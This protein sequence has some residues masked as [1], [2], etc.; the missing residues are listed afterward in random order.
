MFSCIYIDSESS[1]PRNWRCVNGCGGFG[2]LTGNVRVEMKLTPAACA[3]TVH[4]WLCNSPDPTET[5]GSPDQSPAQRQLGSSRH[6]PSRGEVWGEGLLLCSFLSTL[7]NTLDKESL[8]GKAPK[9]LPPFQSSDCQEMLGSTEN[10]PVVG[11]GDTVPKQEEE[12]EQT[13][14]WFL[15]R[16]EEWRRKGF[17]SL[18]GLMRSYG[19]C[20]AAGWALWGESFAWF[21][22]RKHG[23]AVYLWLAWEVVLRI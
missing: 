14:G 1:L 4:D 20:H 5:G 11:M 12:R 2:K 16:W 17:W 19:H 15:P 10:G 18:E 21:N 3:C 22:A 9:S 13:V 7:L 23:C 6:M 8:W